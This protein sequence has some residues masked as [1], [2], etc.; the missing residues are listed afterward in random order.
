MIGRCQEE[1]S[2]RLHVGALHLLRSAHQPI[3]PP[4]AFLD[5]AEIESEKSHKSKLGENLH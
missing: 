2:V 4:I 1:R 5:Q 3:G